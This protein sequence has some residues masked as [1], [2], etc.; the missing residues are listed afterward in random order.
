MLF[1]TS[2]VIVLALSLYISVLM[3]SISVYLYEDIEERLL[4]TSRYAATLIT[5]EELETLQS[6]EDMATPLYADIRQRLI[7]FAEENH[8]LY[9]YYM[10]DVD[11]YAHF[12]VDND[13]SEDTSNLASDPVPWEPVPLRAL[14]GQAAVTPLESYS[15]GY[16][17]LLSAFAPVLGP[18]GDVIALAGVD[19]GDEQVLTVRDNVNNLS[20]FL[21]VSVILGVACGSLN[22]FLHRRSDRARREALDKAVQA[23]QA[24]SMFLSNMS[25]EIRTPMNAIIGMT[26]IAKT[27][28]DPNRKDYCLQ[29]IEDASTHL[30]GVIN[31]ILDMSKI[32]AGKLELAPVPF[33]FSEMLEKVI[34]MN[35]FR[36][37]EKNQGFHTEVDP[38]IPDALVG[39]DQRLAQVI[40]NLLSNAVKFT[41]VQGAIRLTALLQAM[42]GDACIL[43]V[44]V[45]DSGIGISPEQQGRLFHSFE[46]AERGTVRQFGGTGLG[47]AISKRIVEMMD[48]EIWVES[49]LG[50]G[51]VFLFTVRLLR[52]QPPAKAAHVTQEAAP[53]FTGVRV[54]L[55]EDVEVNQE[56]VMALLEPLGMIID[57]V[58]DG[59]EAFDKFAASPKAV[60]VI[61]MD[62]QMPVMD[63]YEATRRIRAL[64]EG[65]KVPIIAMTANVFREDIERCLEAGMNSHVGKPLELKEVLEKLQAQ[66]GDR[67]Q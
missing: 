28:A 56:I 51:A 1:F 22:V 33:S 14:E 46:Q 27:A 59:Q 23:S 39:D 60:D 26:A 62:V 9:V 10:R 57:C 30:L 13:Q 64:P 29:R 2:S 52:G 4:A 32:E 55:A 37:D 6:P 31:D 5:P 8:L 54:L 38:N 66:L 58:A 41:P 3:R 65:G 16:D 49:E 44:S 53:D 47:L 48:G 20:V 40:T 24:K 25:H 42:E 7:R 21:V 43:R 67:R 12:I 17:S 15:Q 50:K 11:G 19:I 36:V 34:V 45:R 18:A 63:G 61:F 35:S